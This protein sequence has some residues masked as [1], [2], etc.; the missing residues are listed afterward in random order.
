MFIYIIGNKENKQKIGFSKDVHKRL[1][2]LQTGNPEKLTLHHY[3]KIPEN[4]VR[5]I[6]K[7]IHSELSYKR[8]SGEWFNMSPEEA[9]LFLD[10]SVIR[11][12]EDD[13]L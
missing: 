8:L 4:R 12:L 2:S 5:L 9:K 13:L 11:W 1:K 3:V 10:F 6:E 7:K